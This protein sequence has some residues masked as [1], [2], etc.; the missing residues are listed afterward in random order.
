MSTNDYSIVIWNVR[1]LNSLAR[2]QVVRNLIKDVK[3]SCVCLPETKLD[4]LDQGLVDR[5]LGP[6]FGGNFCFLPV[7]GTRGGILLA[8]SDSKYKLNDVQLGTY[9]LSATI[10]ENEDGSS[11]SITSVYGPQLDNEK[12]E[13]LEELKQIKQEMRSN[14]IILGDFNLIVQDADKNNA[15]LS[16]GLM[17]SFRAARNILEVIKIKLNG[18]RYTWSSETDSPTLTKKDRMFCTQSWEERFQN[19]L[20]SAISTLVSDHC[21]L[22]LIAN[23]DRPKSNI[24][25]FEQYWLR[26]PGFI[27]TVQQAWNKPVLAADAIRSLHTKLARTSKALR[28]W[29][30]KSVRGLKLRID[31]ACELIFR[32]DLAHEER[33]LSQEE[34]CFRRFLKQKLLR[35]TALDRV[36]IRQRSKQTWIRAGDA[37]TQ[38]FQIKASARKRKN[39]IQH[40]QPENGLAHTQ[41]DKDQEILSF[42]CSYLGEQRKRSAAINFSL[43]PEQELDLSELDE[44]FTEEEIKRAIFQARSDNAPGPDGFIGAF[45]KKCWDIINADI[46]EVINQVAN[47]HTHKLWLLNSAYIA[48]LPKKENALRVSDYRPIS[49]I[50]AFRKLFSKLL[51]NRLAPK[52]QHLVSKNQSVFNKSRNIQDNFL[53]INNKVKELHSTKTPAFS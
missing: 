38:F 39:F 21:P 45:F 16:R 4:F 36:R 51:A 17:Q 40:L 46:V 19:C 10:T 6:A 50:H 29:N 5:I 35:L 25:I 43:L 13:F 18:R 27:E 47:S 9:T 8:V 49:L 31:I 34:I 42:L 32:L 33:S 52:L 44:P 2:Q 7:Q 11:W 14:W 1:G 12:R 20:L 37:N 3:C 22:L 48:L 28:E 24:F 53:F 26:L 30:R 15:N 41:E 23:P